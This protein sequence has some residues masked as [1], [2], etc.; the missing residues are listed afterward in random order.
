MSDTFMSVNTCLLA[1]FQQAFTVV[2]RAGTLRGDAHIGEFMT[3]NT[4]ARAV[5]I[6]YGS[7]QQLIDVVSHFMAGITKRLRIGDLQR[8]IKSTREK[9]PG[10]KSAIGQNPEAAETA[11]SGQPAQQCLCTPENTYGSI[12]PLLD[13]FRLDQGLG[14][15]EV[16]GEQQ[17]DV[18]LRYVTLAAVNIAGA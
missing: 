5:G 10:N 7:A 1:S 16:I 18:Q 6:I 17:F 15:D 13:L 4:D 8:G 9:N 11:V 14:I 12:S 2:D 3:G